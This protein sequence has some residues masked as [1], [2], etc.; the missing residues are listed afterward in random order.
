MVHSGRHSIVGLPWYP[1]IHEQVPLLQIALL[2]QGFRE[3]GSI[4][5][6]V[7]GSGKYTFVIFKIVKT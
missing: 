1:G 2:P 5:N 7:C 6:G 3:H 4:G